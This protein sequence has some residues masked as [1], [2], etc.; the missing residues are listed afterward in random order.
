MPWLRLESRGFARFLGSVTGPQLVLVALWGGG[1][2]APTALPP[3]LL[4][5]LCQLQARSNILVLWTQKTFFTITWQGLHF[6]LLK[7]SK[8]NAISNLVYSHI[9]LIYL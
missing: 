6:Q 7:V 2:I 9:H 4:M 5:P 1:A 8:S 3:P